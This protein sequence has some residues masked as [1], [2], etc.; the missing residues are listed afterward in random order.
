MYLIVGRVPLFVET[1]Y[2]QRW[3][4]AGLW[5]ALQDQTK[6]NV[7]ERVAKEI[8][9]QKKRLGQNTGASLEF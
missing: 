6:N 5:R 3:D 9:G 7:W 4:C 2:E 8:S 1:P